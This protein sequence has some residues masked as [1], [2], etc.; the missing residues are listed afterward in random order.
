MTQTTAGGGCNHL[1]C[2]PTL[3][4]RKF[5]YSVSLHLRAE[6]VKLRVGGSQGHG[7]TAWSL[8]VWASQGWFE[9]WTLCSNQ[10]SG[11]QS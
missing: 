5:V 6:D 1:A 4:F 8:A 7:L 9:C 10:T 3:H 2:G 11:D